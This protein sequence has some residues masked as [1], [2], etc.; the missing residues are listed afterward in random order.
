MRNLEGYGWE[1]KWSGVC[2]AGVQSKKKKNRGKMSNAARNTKENPHSICT[3]R[4][5]KERDRYVGKERDRTYH[6]NT[7]RRYTCRERQ[8][9]EPRVIP[10][11]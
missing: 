3:Q 7:C 1:W 10:M 2:Y 5:G 8:E 9:D 11:E 6:D 4:E